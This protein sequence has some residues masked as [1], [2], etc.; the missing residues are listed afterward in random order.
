MI[1]Q[2]QEHKFYPDFKIYG[3]NDESLT[4]YIANIFRQLHPHY[5][6]ITSIQSEI[7]IATALRYGKV[8]I[9]H[10]NLYPTSI[11]YTYPTNLSKFS[12]IPDQYQNPSNPINL[13]DSWII[14]SLA[15]HNEFRR[16]SVGFEIVNQCLQSIP[17]GHPPFVII[18][19]TNT[20]SLNLF[21]KLGFEQF[22]TTSITNPATNSTSK[23]IC[24]IYR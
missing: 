21:R 24:M 17:Q 14:L 23:S 12:D 3:S 22:S 9:G 18:E 13:Q 11:I 7:F 5:P 15:V 8:I 19:D 16:Q 4:P 2:E 20:P 1:N 10:H 6:D